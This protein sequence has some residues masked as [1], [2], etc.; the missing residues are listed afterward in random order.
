MLIKLKSLLRDIKISSEFK[1]FKEKHP[2]FYL[3]SCFNSSDNWQADFYCPED[4]N[5]TSFTV[6][7]RKVNVETSEIFRKEK[8][9]I[10]ELKIEELKIGINEAKKIVS[11]LIEEKYNNEEVNKEIIILQNLEEP[12]W[13][14]TYITKTLNII[15][16]KIN[17]IS[18]VILEEKKESALSFKA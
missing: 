7:D 18:G 8:K 5:L 14:I 12:L 13:N 9:D 16:V 6:K 11:S 1:E 2:K 3:S 15:H 17:A 4:D 10:K